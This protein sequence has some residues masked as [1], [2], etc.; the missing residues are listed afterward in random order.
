MTRAK[1]Q[2]LVVLLDALAIALFAAIAVIA[3]TGGGVFSIGSMRVSA[4][5]TA[6]PAAALVLMA[7]LRY[8]LA[9]MPAW[10]DRRCAAIVH[11]A[12]DA[13]AHLTGRRAWQIVALLSAATLLVKLANAWSHPGFFSGDDV[14]VQEMSLAALFDASWPAWTLRSAFFPLVFVHPAHLAAAAIGVTDPGT[15]VAAGR[16][17]VALLST[18]TVAFVFIAARRHDGPAAGVIAAFFA[19]TSALLVS[20]GGTELPRPVSAALVTAAFALLL[21]RGGAAA[22]LAGLLVGVA[23]ALRF[24]EAVFLAPAVAML[25]L[26]RRW[27]DA[28]VFTVIAAGTGLGIQAV[29]DQLYWGSPF[30][31]L[32]HA[33]DYTLVEGQSTRGFQPPWHYLVTMPEWCHVAL[34]GVAVYAALRGGWRPALWAGLPILALSALPH[35]EARY[36]IPIVP[37]VCLLAG[38]GLWRLVQRIVRPGSAAAPSAPSWAAAAIVIGTAL[39]TLMSINGFHVRRS[40]G[41]VALAR[42]IAPAQDLSGAGVEQLWRWGGRIYLAHVPNLVEL[43]GRV[44]APADLAAISQDASMTWIA[45]R[46][47]TCDRLGCG[48][49]LRASGYDD[50]S[51]PASIETGY[52]IFR[53]VRKTPPSTAAAPSSLARDTGSPSSSAAKPIAT[54][55]TRFE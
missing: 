25:A 47:D 11:R 31:S 35:K 41:E 30:F 48:D 36:L 2:P 5:S 29:A 8:A 10:L 15:L 37:F 12:H 54:I 34:V 16:T 28:A 6:N 19:A 22:A 32:R 33:V 14:E 38:A 23:A 24:S 13:L 53:R 26:E 50:R 51:T 21:R 42:T 44:G 55:G 46:T 17:A 4:R 3:V 18:L 27:R 9:G 43:D 7:L 49:V 1:T 20:F 52:R 39:V 40:D 45:L